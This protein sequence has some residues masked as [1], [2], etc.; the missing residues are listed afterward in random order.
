[1]NPLE[2]LR[3]SIALLVAFTLLTGLAYPLAITGLSAVI[4][5]QL[6]TGSI[7]ENNGKPVGSALVGQA[8]SEDK[9]AWP[10]PSAAGAGYDGANSS[11]SN[12]GPT[13]SK[14]MDRIRQEAARYPGEGLV[15]QDAV[16]ASGSGLDPDISPENARRQVPRIAK[17]RNRSVEWVNGIVSS[18]AQ[19]RTFGIVGEP[20]VNVLRLNLALDAADSAR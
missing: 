19:G 9:Y 16:T 13:S 5:P 11:G 3:A 20:R 10:R 15:P 7:I 6:A 17:A 2:H 4:A 12:L 8:F 18:V 1:M 14:L